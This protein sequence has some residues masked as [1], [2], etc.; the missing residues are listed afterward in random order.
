MIRPARSILCMFPFL[1]LAAEPDWQALR[2]ETLR[3]FQALVRIDT[4]DPPGHEAPAVEYLKSVLEKEGISV[5]IFARDP[6]RPN[7]VARLRG[8]GKKR[9]VLIMA[10]TDVVGVQPEKWRFPPFSATLHEGFL[11]GRGTVDDKDNVTAALMTLLLLK[12]HQVA[13]DRDVIFLAEAGEEGSVQ[14]GIQY[15]VENHWPEIDAEFTLAEG[16]GVMKKAGQYH[17][18]TVATTEKTPVRVSLVARGTS[19]HGSRP[20]ADNAIVHLAQAIARVSAWHTPIR[21]NDTTRTYFERLATISP[22]EEA[23]RYNGV[24]VP[25][26]AAS[27]QQYFLEHEPMH[28][29]MLRT[30]V[31]PTIIRGGFRSNVI[32][33]EAEVVLDVRAHPEEKLE[34]LFAEMK[35]VIGNPRVEVV[36]KAGHRPMAP[37]SRIDTE[38]FR[39]LERAQKLIYPGAVTL[40]Y[41]STGASDKVF[42]QQRGVQT[43]GIGPAV[44]EEDAAKGYGAH[45]DQERLAEE[46][47]HRFVRFNW[48][49]VRAVAAQ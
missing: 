43:Y 22:P 42:L 25:E 45:A 35:R 8:S 10:H 29:S 41:M 47:L 16:G 46:E 9:P 1:S 6:K 18:M 14:Y 21:L 3:H 30:S 20:T 15:M 17:R 40:P 26:R 38:M 36:W 13:L 33:S 2:Q 23:A 37:P 34:E 39:A 49:V 44:D 4:S 5:K 24:L 31:V 7:L 12:R 48:E 27:I 11:Y 28:Y 19:G 32:P